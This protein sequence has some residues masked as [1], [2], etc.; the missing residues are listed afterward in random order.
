MLSISRM[1]GNVKHTLGR[2]GSQV[3][4][5]S[6][7]VLEH[8]LAWICDKLLYGPLQWWDDINN[9]VDFVLTILLCR[10][11][12]ML[13]NIHLQTSQN[14]MVLPMGHPHFLNCVGVWALHY[15]PTLLPHHLHLPTKLS[16]WWWPSLQHKPRTQPLSLLPQVS[17]MLLPLCCSLFHPLL[18]KWR[19]SLLTCCSWKALTSPVAKLHSKGSW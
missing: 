12:G 11:H 10:W 16:S 14:L 19:P 8:I 9:M 17:Y 3:P 4:V 13:L 15:R 2:M 18:R 6:I 7:Q 5:T 1:S